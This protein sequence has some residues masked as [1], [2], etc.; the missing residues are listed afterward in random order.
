MGDVGQNAEK[1]PKSKV[2]VRPGKTISAESASKSKAAAQKQVSAESVSTSV[3][4]IRSFAALVHYGVSRMGAR[5]G[6]EPAGGALRSRRF[7]TVPRLQGNQ[8][9]ADAAGDPS[10]DRSI[11]GGGLCK[12]KPSP[13]LAAKGSKRENAFDAAWMTGAAAGCLGKKEAL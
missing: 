13:G 12:P 11:S 4:S 10:G 2:A 6:G 3:G 5:S 9:R 8:T 1:P 7:L